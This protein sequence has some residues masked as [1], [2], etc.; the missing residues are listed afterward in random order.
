MSG[1]YD[2]LRVMVAVLAFALPLILWLGGLHYGVHL[3]HSMSDYY[4]A[5]PKYLAPPCD[6]HEVDKCTKLPINILDVSAGTMR[7]YFVGCLFAVGAI[8]IIYRGYT[9]FENWLLNFAGVMAFCVAL[10]PM[11]WT[12]AHPAFDKH[13]A[14]AVLFFAA[15]AIDCIFCSRDTLGL[16][17]GRKSKNWY[18]WAYIFFAFL[19]IASMLVAWRLNVIIKHENYIYWIEFCGI[20]SFAA[21]WVV[22]TTELHAIGSERRAIEE[23]VNFKD[24]LPKRAR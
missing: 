3:R 18:Y 13:G 22:K 12:C 21:Y 8:L 9:V 16:L 15:I 20:Y 17:H 14:S 24:G 7:S 11:D 6:T 23:R 4:W 10:F 2:K 1:T 19:M 5:S